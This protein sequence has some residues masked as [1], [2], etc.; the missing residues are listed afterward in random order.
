MNVNKNK[1][2]LEKL[3]E[4]GEFV[5]TAELGPPKSVDPSVID[6]KVI[7][8]K[9]A[10]DAVNITDNQAAIVRISSIG[11]GIYV[12]NAGIEP[13]IQM[14]C[15]DRNR[16]GIQA[17]LLGASLNGI[18]NLLCIT[19]DHQSLGN[20]PRARCVF[21]IDSIQLIGMVRDMREKGVFQCGEAIRNGKHADVH[22]PGFFIGGAANP[23]AE[24]LEWRVD[25]LRKK[26][27][28]GVEFIQTQCIYDMERF[29]R[30]MKEV[31]ARGLHGQVKICAGV[32]P[33]K[34]AGAAVYMNE[35]VAGIVI[36]D[37]CIE[38]LRKADDAKAEG[39]K[40]CIE[41]IQQLMEMEGVAG[42]HII[43]IEWETAVRGIVEGAGLL[44]RPEMEE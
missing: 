3:F 16:L 34:S 30:W 27:N 14:T 9:G 18:K 12:K 6:A 36:P 44:P 41:Q 20:H 42:V 28:A 7:A 32:S 5:V 26:V 13:I 22:A 31:T 15:R 2:G 4:K 17:D 8:L 19:G 37:H 43:A 29:S 39:L 11:T 23:F 21:D 1:S 38:R 33:L 25:R 40:I 35:K 10:V 24:P